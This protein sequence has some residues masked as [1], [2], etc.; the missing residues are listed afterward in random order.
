MNTQRA[1]SSVTNSSFFIAKDGH[2]YGWGQNL[3]NKLVYSVLVVSN[4]S[5][6]FC[7]GDKIF[8][9]EKHVLVK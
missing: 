8:G 6:F 3:Q 7:D 1:F 2:L 9:G 4:V 5:Y